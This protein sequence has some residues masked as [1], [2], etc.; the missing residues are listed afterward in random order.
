MNGYRV[1]SPAHDAT[2]GRKVGTFNVWTGDRE[3][4]IALAAES[5]ERT[6]AEVALADMPEAARLNLER[7]AAE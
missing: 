7:A 2:T 5:P 6:W 3:R 4:A 1:T